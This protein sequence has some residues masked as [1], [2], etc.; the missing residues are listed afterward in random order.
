M[1]GNAIS[2]SCNSAKLDDLNW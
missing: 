2:T 1:L